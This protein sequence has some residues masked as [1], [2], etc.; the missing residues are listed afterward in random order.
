MKTIFAVLKAD[1][2]VRKSTAGL[3]G[4]FVGGLGTSMADG[5]LDTPEVI[6]ALGAALVVAAA[7]WRIP[8]AK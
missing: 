5:N 8:N 6:V 1:K 4:T 3:V 7:V 2:R